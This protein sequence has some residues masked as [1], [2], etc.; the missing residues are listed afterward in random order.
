MC[1]CLFYFHEQK[2]TREQHALQDSPK[3]LDHA[4]NQAKTIA[5]LINACVLVPSDLGP[6]TRHII[7]CWFPSDLQCN[8][9]DVLATRISSAQPGVAQSRMAL[10]NYSNLPVYI[11][12]SLG[13]AMANAGRMASLFLLIEFLLSIML[14]HPSE[15][16]FAVITIVWLLSMGSQDEILRMSMDEKGA[17]V[18]QV[19]SLF[20]SRAKAV[21]PALFKIVNLPPLPSSFV[22]EYPSLTPVLGEVPESGGLPFDLGNVAWL[23]DLFPLRSTRKDTCSLP[24]QTSGGPDWQSMMMAMSKTIAESMKSCMSSQ[25]FGGLNLTMCERK[26]R[27][28]HLMGGSRSCQGALM[29]GQVEDGEP[30]SIKPRRALKDELEDDDDEP[31]CEV[32][33]D[34]V[35]P[36][37]VGTSIELFGNLLKRDKDKA[38]K[39]KREKVDKAKREKE[40]LKAASKPITGKAKIAGAKKKAKAAVK[41]KAKIEPKST[42]GSPSKKYHVP[43]LGCSKCRYA[44]KGCSECKLRRE[45]ILKMKAR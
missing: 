32:E 43:P 29:D 8:L 45:R 6:I 2:R 31:E 19:K 33:G 35:A 37:A 11:R 14:R 41:A 16:T 3:R 30:I 44:P 36:K 38:D 27:A 17:A 28:E 4:K 10:Q 20:R 7:A 26:S 22:L 42:A 25:R 9:V 21:G 39:A 40:E 5:Q 13:K 12:D 24:M 23:A 18:K 34:G 1:S 15:K